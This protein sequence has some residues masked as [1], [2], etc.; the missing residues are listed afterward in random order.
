MV[1]GGR[2]REVVMRTLY[3]T[4]A[5]SVFTALAAADDKLAEPKAIEKIELL[6]GK[7][8][9]DDTRQGAWLSP[10]HSSTMRGSTVCICAF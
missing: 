8:E 10:F 7:T 5:V 1:C 2:T 4:V 3:L 6:G 9:R